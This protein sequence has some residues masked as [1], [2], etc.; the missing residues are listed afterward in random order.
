M[1]PKKNPRAAA[2]DKKAAAEA[3][4]QAA[5]KAEHEAKVADSWKSGSKDTSKQEQENQKRLE[6]LAKKAEREALLAA[7]EAAIGGKATKGDKKGG[8]SS[9]GASRPG[10]I[11]DFLGGLGAGQGQNVESYAASGLDGALELLS[12]AS[13]GSASN[14]DTLDR[15]PERRLKSAYAAF[16]ERE[17]PILKSENPGLRLS[18]LKQQLQKMWKK[19]PENPLNQV[20]VAYDATREDVK[21]IINAKRE[22]DLQKFQTK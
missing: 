13:K 17:M 21:E 18:Q 20:N 5:K 9:S 19:S 16:E 15:H 2:M 6:L 4:K 8:G 10:R 14:S 12:L 3:E 1:P 11:D 22:E 7:E